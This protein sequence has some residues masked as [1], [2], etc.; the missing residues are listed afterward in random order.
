MM[1]KYEETWDNCDRVCPYC[2]HRYQVEAENYSED[3][4]EED[5]DECGKKFYGYESF[6]VSHYSK[7]DCELNGD[8]HKWEPTPISGG[9]SHDFCSVCGE[10]RP[11]E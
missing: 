2:A 5:C 8:E 11:F 3:V 7:P 10:C 1:S 4:R 6:S 9:R